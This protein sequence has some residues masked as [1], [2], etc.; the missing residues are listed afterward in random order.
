MKHQER[1]ELGGVSPDD[2]SKVRMSVLEA[3]GSLQEKQ[4]T[5]AVT[6]SRVPLKLP[7]LKGPQ[8]ETKGTGRVIQGSTI[9]TW[10]AVRLSDLICLPF[11]F[12]SSC[13]ASGHHDLPHPQ[14]CPP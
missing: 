8:R 9:S 2:Q 11:M 1:E 7:P 10:Q 13:V 6:F 5:T 14:F 12:C 3:T 4:P